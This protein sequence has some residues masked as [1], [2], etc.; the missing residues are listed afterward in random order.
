LP[1]DEALRIG[2]ELADALYNAH[3]GGI[4]HRD[5][6][7]ANIMLTKSGAKLL[8]F[9]LARINPTEASPS[10]SSASTRADVTAEGVLLGTLQY[11]APEQLEGREADSR[12]DIF[13]FGS[14]L[15]EMLTGSKAFEGTSQAK[16]IVAIL[17]REP[18]LLPSPAFPADLSRLVATCLAKDPDERWQ[19]ASDIKHL[20]L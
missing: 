1:L 5:I 13:A 7:P 16:L 9:G 20:D 15:Y 8:D 17:E 10:Q 4:V 14:T 3:K 11:M 18:P 12:T 19:N 2:I 6:K